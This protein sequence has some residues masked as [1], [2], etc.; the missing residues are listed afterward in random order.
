MIDAL[1]KH[2]LFMSVMRLNV[3]TFCKSPAVAE[4][5]QHPICMQTGTDV[6]RRTGSPFTNKHQIDHLCYCAALSAQWTKLFSFIY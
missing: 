2:C 4:Q 3:A 6:H 1:N 5:T